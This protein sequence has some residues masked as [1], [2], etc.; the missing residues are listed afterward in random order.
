MKTEGHY[1]MNKQP[2]SKEEK[3][4]SSKRLMY[5]IGIPFLLWIIIGCSSLLI[6]GTSMQKTRL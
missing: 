2:T 3:E 5:W 1:Y 4:K 6:G